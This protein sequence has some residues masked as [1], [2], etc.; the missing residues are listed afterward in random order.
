[1]IQFIIILLA[2]LSSIIHLNAQ[3]GDDLTVEQD[4]YKFEVKVDPQQKKSLFTLWL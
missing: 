1:M 3:A 4:G 2:G